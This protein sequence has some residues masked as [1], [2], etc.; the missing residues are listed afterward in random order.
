MSN[1]L[2]QTS[3][4]LSIKIQRLKH[5][6]L[7]STIFTSFSLFMFRAFY[8]EYYLNWLLFVLLHSLKIRELFI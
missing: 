7:I 3:T 5:D 1:M 2:Y 4:E 8:Y 6:P